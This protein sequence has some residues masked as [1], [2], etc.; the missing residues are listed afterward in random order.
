MIEAELE[1]ERKRASMLHSDPL[2][3][4]D[5]GDSLAFRLARLPEVAA[6]P[7]ASPD[8]EGETF[9]TPAEEKSKAESELTIDTSLKINRTMLVLD[10]E[11]SPT[12]GTA[13]FIGSS[14]GPQDDSTTPEPSSAVTTGTEETFFDNEP[15]VDS[16]PVAKSQEIPDGLA[17][18]VF[19]GRTHSLYG[20]DRDDAESIQIMLRGTPVSARGTGFDGSRE[21]PAPG[22]EERWS[23]SE[24]ESPSFGRVDERTPSRNRDDHHASMSSAASPNE[25]LWSPESTASFMS[26]NTTL[27]GDSYSTITRVFDSY[28][29]PNLMSPENITE[30]QRRMASQSPSLARAGGWD[31]KKVTQIYLQQLREKG[32]DTSAIPKPLNVPFN[33]SKTAPVVVKP[34]DS[35]GAENDLSAIDG[36][37]DEVRHEAADDDHAVDGLAVPSRVLNLQRA[38]LTNPDDW[39]NTSPSM[40][41]WMS[42]AVDTPTDEKDDQVG[43][44]VRGWVTGISELEKTQ[45]ARDDRPVLPDI[46]RSGGLGININ[47]E[48]PPD[49]LAPGVPEVHGGTDHRASPLRSVQPPRSP[50]RK[51]A[52]SS[53]SMNKSF[54][55]STQSGS[56]G[57]STTPGSPSRSRPEDLSDPPVTARPLAEIN[58]TVTEQQGDSRPSL[59][60][61]HSN[62]SRPATSEL[63]KRLTRRRHII[64]E[65]VN[66]ESSFSQDMTVVVDIYKGTSNVILNS[67]DDVKTLFGNAHDVVAFSTT[68][69]DSLKTAAKSVYLLPKSKR[70]RS[71]R[72]SNATTESTNTD[73]QSSIGGIDLTDED[74][75]RKTSIGSAFLKNLSEMERVYAEYL[76]N[77]DAANQKLQQLQ[78]A[79]KIQIWLRECQ[80]YASD[81][82]TAWDLD[83]LLVKPVQRLLKYSLFLKDLVEVTAD[84]H[85]D[86]VPLDTACREMLSVSHRINEAKKRAELLEQV[87]GA[88]SG[89]KK[90]KD[91]EGRLA[92]PKAF[93]RRSE[94]LKQQVGLSD[95]VQDRDYNQVADKFGSHFFQLQVVMRDVEMYVMDVQTWVN[96]FNDVVLGIEAYMD[97]GQTTYPNLES[98]WR[99]FRLSM[100]EL[101]MTALVDH[102]SNRFRHLT[103][104]ANS[105]QINAVRKNVIDP[106]TTLL[107]L[108][109]GPQRLMDKRKKRVMDFA[110]YKA[111]KDR[112]EKPDKKTAEQGEQFLAINET[113]KDE[114]PKLF[115]LTGKLVEACLN[116]Y[117]QLQLQWQSVWKR[118]LVQAIELHE[119]PRSFSAIFVDFSGDFRYTEAQV[120]SLGVCNG[121]LL[122]DTA[123][124]VN[125]SYLTPSTTLNDDDSSRRPSIATDGSRTR[126]PSTTAENPRV[127]QYSASSGLS[128]MLP[129]PDFGRPTEG[130]GLGPHLGNSAHQP[131]TGRRVR[132]SSTASSRSPVTPDV[133]G[134]WRT[135]GNVPSQA[136]SHS[137]RPSTST[138]RSHETHSLPVPNRGGEGQVEDQ[139]GGRLRPDSE[140]SR[141]MAPRQAPV[142][143]KRSSQSDRASGVF[144]SAMPMSDSPR[145]QSPENDG[146][147]V[148]Q[149]KVLF[150]AA[151]VYEFNIDRARREAGY[152]YLTYVAGE[153]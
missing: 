65:L 131:G 27:D 66:T 151:S 1:E 124:L 123:N 12:L 63:Q 135:Y 40:L 148:P 6:D 19:E 49:G 48:S 108:H 16:H 86:F 13:K 29:D 37:K 41:D 25:Q 67:P 119:V 87:N 72:D 110:K 32:Q 77:H 7:S 36:A 50:V 21:T 84:N 141:F 70:W 122:A 103:H 92:F 101:Q 102:V 128:P 11:D 80:T 152:P 59:S 99:R 60:S 79:E 139:G 30:L 107:K 97:V 8:Q 95:M 31:A 9:T 45:T 118:K 137:N 28:H 127:R 76:R 3:V 56:L 4:D 115:S 132:A 81:L 14:A 2:P 113:L 117:V 88:G 20:S 83:S 145:A 121:S 26:G 149:Y 64:E 23:T 54:Q 138:G 134:G 93:G 133:P 85:P 33:A 73:D 51:P 39:A 62:K 114:L 74:K 147:H 94:K 91:Y 5:R 82:T 71:K 142:P 75:D 69:L 78:K 10:T 89:S 125:L 144:S 96:S 90:R 22:S 24:Q 44:Q 34:T 150:L 120:L 153:V 46:P 52:S 104:Q 146:E 129:S 15:Q 98:K 58:S 130:F 140:S 116:N 111:V 35:D 57:P 143:N 47:V 126:A 42:Q 43:R 112:G 53:S 18:P 100:R 38:S 109:D 17:P 55:T 68:F 105:T 106:M 136:S 61:E